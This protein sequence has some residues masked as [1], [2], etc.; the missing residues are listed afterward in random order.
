[1]LILYTSFTKQ[2]TSNFC[3]DYINT[4]FDTIFTDI[5]TSSGLFTICLSFLTFHSNLSRKEGDVPN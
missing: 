2:K 3:R 1:M 5:L 4:K